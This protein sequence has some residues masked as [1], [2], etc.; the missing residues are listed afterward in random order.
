MPEESSFDRKK[1]ISSTI[2]METVSRVDYYVEEEKRSFSAMVEILL[3]EA[4]DK[5]DGIKLSKSKSNKPVKK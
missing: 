5:R 4:L 1:Q 2:T 3:N